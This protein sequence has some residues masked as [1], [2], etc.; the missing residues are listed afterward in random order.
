MIKYSYEDLI[1]LSKDERVARAN[2]KIDELKVFLDAAKF[3]EKETGAKVTVF[4]ADDPARIDP[5]S[6][7]Q[8]AMPLRP[9]IYIE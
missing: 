6:R 1:N 5:K 3:L 8:H 2:I 7:A 4:R 9:A